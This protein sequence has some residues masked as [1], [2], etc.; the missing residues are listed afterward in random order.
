[1][2]DRNEKYRAKFLESL[3]GHVDGEPRAVG[4]FM[5]PGA[6]GAMALMNVSGLAGLLAGRAGKKKSGGLPQN[7]VLGVTDD[8]V[9]VFAYKPKGTS[10]KLKDPIAVWDRSSVRMERTSS[11]AMSSRVMIHLADGES[12]ELDTPKMPGTSSDFNAP[13]IDL[14]AD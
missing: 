5:R 13:L 6:Y 3:R 8:K 7:V 1:M 2:S 12:I 4:I 14:L 10:L 11:G 9:H